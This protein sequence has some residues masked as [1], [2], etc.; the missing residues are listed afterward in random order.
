M[1]KKYRLQDVKQVW[2]I[3]K[4]TDGRNLKVITL[5]SGMKIHARRK[6]TVYISIPQYTYIN[7]DVTDFNARPLLRLIFSKQG[8]LVY[9][10]PTLEKIKEYSKLHLDSL[11]ER[12]QARSKPARL[13]SRPF[14]EMLRQ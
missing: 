14:T 10:L 12:I 3:T 5:R 2:R 9:E 4:K 11:W 8:E 6:I 13:S 7:K 1:P